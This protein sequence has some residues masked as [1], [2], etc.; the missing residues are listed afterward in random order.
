MA[1]TDTR[2]HTSQ[3]MSLQ[4][5][6][7]RISRALRKIKGTSENDICKYL[8]YNGGYMHHF[9]L[10]KL[11]SEAPEKLS[12]MIDDYIMQVEKPKRVPHKPRK[13]RGSRKRPDLIT[14]TRDELD[15]ILG[16]VREAGDHEMAAKFSLKGSLPAIKRALISNI[17]Q[18]KVDWELWNAYVEAVRPEGS[19]DGAG[20]TNS[21]FVQVL[22]G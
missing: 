4:D 12:E 8:P 7:G 20:P 3:K 14:L 2:E 11:K 10:R 18:N 16:H 5:L 9:T 17:R 13:P 21:A 15:R 1:M 22:G 6:E 19:G